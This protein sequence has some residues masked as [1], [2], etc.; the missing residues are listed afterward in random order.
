MSGPDI[1][2]QKPNFLGGL[3]RLA[4]Q[5]ALAI[6]A[7][8]PTFLTCIIRPSRLRALIDYEELEG[9]KGV[10]LSPGTFFV[11]SL[12]LSFIIA[13]MLSTPETRDYNGSYIGPDLAVAV[14]TAA[15]EGNIW[16][17]VGTLMPIY[18]GAV[19]LGVIGAVLKPWAQQGW[20]LRVSIRAAFYVIGA[21]I[22]WILL[23]TA[24]I[25]L[26]RVNGWL[27]IKVSTLYTAVTIPAIAVI[28]WMYAG[29]FRKDGA[30]SWRRSAVLA[31]AMFGLII[32]FMIVT[33]LLLRI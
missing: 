5:F 32:L 7:V 11:L 22:S 17:L 16:K 19:V 8:I 3:D 20:S 12:F 9:R 15:S 13:A 23:T 10:L 26:I 14:Q 1:D 2:L 29:F 21:L 24:I 30:V 18:G 4:T 28:M 27:N 6:I 25:D 31:A 33:D